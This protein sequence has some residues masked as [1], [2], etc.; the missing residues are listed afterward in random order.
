VGVA[1]QLPALQVRHI[2][3]QPWRASA[4]LRSDLALDALEQPLYDRGVGDQPLVEH[5]DRGVAGECDRSPKHLEVGRVAW[6]DHEV[7]QRSGQGGRRCSG[8]TRTD[9]RN[10]S[11]TCRRC[12]SGCRIIAGE[13][14]RPWRADPDE[15]ASAILEAVQSQRARIMVAVGIPAQDRP[16]AVRKKAVTMSNEIPDRRI[17]FRFDVDT[18]CCLN[19]GM[20]ALLDLA[21]ELGVKFTFFVNPGRAVSRRVLPS[22]KASRETAAKLSSLRKLGW[23]SYLYT[24]T[25]NPPLWRIDRAG[26]VARA[27]AQGHEV[28]LHGGRNHALWQRRAHDW[29]KDKVRSEIEWGLAALHAMGVAEIKS[30]ASPGW[31]TPPGL[32]TILPDYGIEVLADDHG[33]E[34]SRVTQTTDDSAIRVPTNLLGEPGGVGFLEWQIAQQFAPD[35][36]VSLFAK[37][38]LVSHT[39]CHV[40]YDHPCFAGREGLPLFNRLIKFAQSQNKTIATV[41]E[42]GNHLLQSKTSIVQGNGYFKNSKSS[43]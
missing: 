21:Q 4:T 13:V 19:D 17:C 43:L 15:T 32:D 28:G 38:L 30:F 33:P 3:R 41:T 12:N 40:L 36:S 23:R 20:P 42:I 2:G 22:R 16:D 27:V 6:E 26:H 8:S 9:C 14:G 35:S 39:D 5:S 25:I 34:C 11:A 7:R 24:A 37:N 29:H 31:N 1:R 10:R 18:P